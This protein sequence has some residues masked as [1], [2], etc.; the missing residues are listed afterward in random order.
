MRACLPEGFRCA[1]RIFYA[2]A[3]CFDRGNVQRR[4][5]LYSLGVYRHGATICCHFCVPPG[6]GATGLSRR[7]SAACVRMVSAYLAEEDSRESPRQCAPPSLMAHAATA[8]GHRS[9]RCHTGHNP[10]SFFSPITPVSPCP[11]SSS[12]PRPSSY[13]PRSL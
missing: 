5:Y 3:Y 2:D 13:P 4:G 6:H 12:A 10:Y 8:T 11:S 7:P 1:F 9:A